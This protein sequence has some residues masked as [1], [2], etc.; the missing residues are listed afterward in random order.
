MHP[1]GA[2]RGA[3]RVEVVFLSFSCWLNVYAREP[4][5]VEQV[6]AGILVL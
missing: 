4:P 1:L 5:A 3:R 2:P 6:F